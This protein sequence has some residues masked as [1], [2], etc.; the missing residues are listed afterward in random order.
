MTEARPLIHWLLFCSQKMPNKPYVE[1]LSFFPSYN[2]KV[3]KY[4]S[5]LNSY[6]LLPAEISNVTGNDS[7]DWTRTVKDLNN[8]IH[9]QTSALE[10]LASINTTKSSETKKS[11]AKLHDCQQ[12]LILAVSS[13]DGLQ[14]ADS[15]TDFAKEFYKQTSAQNTKLYLQNTLHSAFKC[16]VHISLGF[17]T[18]IYQG[19]FYC[20]SSSLPRQNTYR[21]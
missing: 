16:N 10:K 17:A 15:A 4:F 2:P 20:N 5:D 21:F 14:S 1:E 18:A 11:F 12:K 3:L 19:L 6:N 9:E 13:V 7:V 8:N